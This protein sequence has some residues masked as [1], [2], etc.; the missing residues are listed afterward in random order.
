[1]SPCW[2][3]SSIAYCSSIVGSDFGRKPQLTAS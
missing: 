2:R 3:H 1:V